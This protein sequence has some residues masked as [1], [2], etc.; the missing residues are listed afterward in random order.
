[1]ILGIQL[2]FSSEI[3]RTVTAAPALHLVWSEV[4]LLRLLE[5]SLH[6]NVT[7]FAPSEVSIAAFDVP[8]HQRGYGEYKNH[9]Q[10]CERPQSPAKLRPSDPR[11]RQRKSTEDLN[12][13]A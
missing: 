12:P 4:L 9:I 2:P 7:P 6:S 8:E 11:I 1:V 3:S 13:Y 10:R 5:S